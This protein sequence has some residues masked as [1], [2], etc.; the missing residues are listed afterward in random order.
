MTCIKHDLRPVIISVTSPH[1]T[2]AGNEV[3]YYYMQFVDYRACV[4]MWKLIGV[5]W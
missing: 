1:P 4:F 5:V 3:Y 2:L